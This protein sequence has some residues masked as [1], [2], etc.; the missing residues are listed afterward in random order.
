MGAYDNHQSVVPAYATKEWQLIYPQLGTLRCQLGSSAPE[1]RHSR[2][3]FRERCRLSKLDAEDLELRRISKCHIIN[4]TPFLHLIACRTILSWNAASFSKRSCDSL[5]SSSWFSV[6][7]NVNACHPRWR[8]IITLSDEIIQSV[9]DARPRA[10]GIQKTW[11]N[12]H[13]S[14][15]ADMKS[16][17]M[18]E[19]LEYSG[20]S[21]SIDK[22]SSFLGTTFVAPALLSIVS[23]VLNRFL[24]RS[25]A[26]ILPFPF[27][28]ALWIE[29]RQ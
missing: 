20:S 11:H 19:T 22:K 21:G 3:L 24:S 1:R 13:G 18:W 15:K 7:V 17:Y 5:D 9:Y 25:K 2:F 14:S 29:R 16:T 26:V 28:S 8:R 23:N 12:E 27:I 10:R 6:S 4:R